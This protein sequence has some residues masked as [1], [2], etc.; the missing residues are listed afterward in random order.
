MY[1]FE[2]AG[3]LIEAGL[4][5]LSVSLEQRQPLLSVSSPPF[6]SSAYIRT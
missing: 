4:D 3:Y 5:G 2:V 6:S 1:E